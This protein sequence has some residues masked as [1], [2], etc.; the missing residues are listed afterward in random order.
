MLQGVGIKADCTRLRKYLS[1]DSQGI[2]E[3]SHLYK[4]VKFASGDAKKIN[5]AMVSLAQQVEEHL[6]LPLEKGDVRT[7]DWSNSQDLTYKQTQCKPESSFSS[8][9]MI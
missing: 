1:I 2:L 4:L 6:Q 8:S 3:L 5:K 9:R 7:G